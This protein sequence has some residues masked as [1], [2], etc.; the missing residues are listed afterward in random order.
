MKKILTALTVS[1]L[2]TTGFAE[3]IKIDVE[4]L[5]PSSAPSITS[6]GK[7]QGVV[8]F[9]GR[10][11]PNTCYISSSTVKQT[12]ELEDIDMNSLRKK[13]STANPKDFDI[14]LTGC[15]HTA[16]IEEEEGLNIYTNV[17]IKF[18][19]DAKTVTDDGYLKDTSNAANIAKNVYIQIANK[20]GERINLK[21][22]PVSISQAL[23]NE[24]HESGDIKFSFTASYYSTGNATMGDIVTSIPFDIVYK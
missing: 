1:L 16:F 23:N 19:K 22:D 11:K 17:A 2:A 6:S 21:T 10:I 18:D 12:I 9:L 20:S 15:P 5:T 7:T 8:D 4:T 24:T 3:E 13:N 14:V